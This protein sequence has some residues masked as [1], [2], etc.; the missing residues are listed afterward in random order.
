MPSEPTS[1]LHAVTRRF[2]FE[3]AYFGIGGV[4]LASLLDPSVIAA[5]KPS[6]GGLRHAGRASDAPSPGQ[7]EAGHSPVHGRRAVA[8]R[9][10]RSEAGADQARRP[11]GT[12]GVHP[13]RALRLHQGHAQA[14]GQPV[15]V[16]PARA[17]GGAGLRAPA[18]DG[19]ARRRDRDRALDAHDAVQPCAG[20][21]L[22]EH[23][24]PGDRASELRLVAQLRAREREHRPAGLRGA[25]LG[26]EQP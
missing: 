13:G 22:H 26:R 4:A 6:V 8:A 18:V 9:S 16:P 1:R 20:A 3:Q 25:P 19:E 21:D 14:P 23:R 24:A 10:L 17:V 2:F 15:H 11:G 7:G 12:G 5:Q